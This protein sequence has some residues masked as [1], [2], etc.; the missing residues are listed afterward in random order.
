MAIVNLSELP[1]TTDFLV[2]G[3]G[4]VG[5]TVALELARRHPD[6]RI[7]ILDKENCLAAHASGR[8]S[9]VLHAGFY[10]SADT[11]KARLCR[12]GNEALTAYCLDRG[13]PINPCGK[14]VLARNEAEQEGICLLFERG[15]AN[16]VPLQMISEYEARSIEPRVRTCGRALWSPTTSSI[17]PLALMA[18][19]ARDARLL[20][21]RVVLG[22]RFLGRK[23]TAIETSAGIV[24]PG[25]TVNAAGL[26]ADQVARAFGFGQGLAVFPFKGLYLYGNDSA[27]VLRVHVYPVPDLRLPF[28]G[29]H[30]TT[31]V[32]GRVKIG[33]TALPCL[34]TE[35][36]SILENFDCRDLAR[37]TRL[38]MLM[39]AK[40]GRRYLRLAAGELMKADRACLTAQAGALVE[41]IAPG[42]FTHWG[43]PGI[44]A[45]MVDIN[46]G[47]LVMDFLSKGDDR[48][49]HILNAVSPALTSSLPLAAHCCD[50]MA[51]LMG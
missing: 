7:T 38:G 3:A 19:L 43:R 44:R 18:S 11:L 49:Y 6:C 1:E 27:P 5:L 15:R 29:A 32:K 51:A 9:G 20:G 50:E 42:M 10:Y 26:Q 17:D 22:A 30:F 28:L 14:L 33:P 31:T 34:W 47:R 41:G 16:M 40:N 23:K 39:L 21:I 4:I 46:S 24:Q 35:Q 25:Y 2:V 8:N 13:L 48:S 12:V 36:Y 37:T 45:Q